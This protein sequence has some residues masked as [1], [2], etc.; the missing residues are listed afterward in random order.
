MCRFLRILV[1]YLALCFNRLNQ[2][3]TTVRNGAK[4]LLFM[5]KIFQIWNIILFCP[6][7]FNFSYFCSDESKMLS[8]INSRRQ[9]FP[10]WQPFQP[11]IGWKQLGLKLRIFCLKFILI[12]LR[13]LWWWE[14]ALWGCGRLPALHIFNGYNWGFFF[15]PAFYVYASS[16]TYKIWL[17]KKI[18][19]LTN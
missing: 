13:S 1:T 15:S 8:I 17:Q 7:R 14:S 4:F 5:N 16:V 11:G 10:G 18:Y 2:F 12:S 3:L 19:R 9:R 6:S